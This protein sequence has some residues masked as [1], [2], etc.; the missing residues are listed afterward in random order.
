VKRYPQ[1]FI[2]IS[3]KQGLLVTKEY[4]VLLYQKKLTNKILKRLPSIFVICPLRQIFLIL[5]A[6]PLMRKLLQHYWL[7]SWIIR[8]TNK[9]G[10]RPNRRRI[11]D[12]LNKLLKQ[13]NASEPGKRG[14]I[15]K[16]INQDKYIILS[17]SA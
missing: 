5:K 8:M 4:R 11:H 14:L 6:K 16:L 3:G 10:S 1:F 15:F 2:G 13:P 7:S 9:Y 17:Q 12:A